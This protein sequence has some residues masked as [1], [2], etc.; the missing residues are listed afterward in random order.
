VK[1]RVHCDLAVSPARCRRRQW[2]Q[3]S[4]GTELVVSGT[5]A[6]GTALASRNPSFWESVALG[7]FY[8]VIRG[9][10]LRGQFISSAANSSMRWAASSSNEL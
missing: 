6:E 3:P 1:G 7:F 9:K 8:V 10:E 4:C 2:L 5:G